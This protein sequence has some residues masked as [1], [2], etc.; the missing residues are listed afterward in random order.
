M[1]GDRSFARDAARVSAHATAFIQAMQGKGWPPAPST[2]PVTAT[3]I[4][5]ATSRCRASTTA[6]SASIASSSRP[7]A[8]RSKLAWPA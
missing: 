5:T 8:R 4:S 3:R 1:I 7:F 2:S 6:A